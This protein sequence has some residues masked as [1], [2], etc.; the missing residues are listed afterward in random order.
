MPC[1]TRL[2]AWQKHFTWEEAKPLD[3]QWLTD[4]LP[5]FVEG[6]SDS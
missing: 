5:R 6:E 1:C 4:E 2:I 3:A